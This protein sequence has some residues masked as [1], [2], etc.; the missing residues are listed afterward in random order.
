MHPASISFKEHYPCISSYLLEGHEYNHSRWVFPGRGSPPWYQA[1]PQQYIFNNFLGNYRWTPQW[2][3]WSHLY[4]LAITFLPDLENLLNSFELLWLC[5][6]GGVSLWNEDKDSDGECQ[7]CS[8]VDPKEHLF[9]EKLPFHRIRNRIELAAASWRR[10]GV[11]L[12]LHLINMIINVFLNLLR[13]GSYYFAWGGCG[14][15]VD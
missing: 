14:R 6:C 1:M 13:T 8:M 15:D 12:S 7:P 10:L 9:E 4:K 2:R 3:L 11:L 5:D